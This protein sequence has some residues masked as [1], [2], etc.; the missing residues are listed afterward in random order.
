MSPF[1]EKAQVN[2]PGISINLDLDGS[3]ENLAHI[4]AVRHLVIPQCRI[5]VD[6]LEFVVFRVSRL[7]GPL[8][9]NVS[10]ST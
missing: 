5:L 3:C 9:M 7:T 2:T 6:L 8:K 4:R 1:G 10:T